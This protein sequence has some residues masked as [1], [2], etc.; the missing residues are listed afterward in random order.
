MSDR[1][2]VGDEYLSEPSSQKVIATSGVR[3]CKHRSFQ[4]NP[5]H[6]EEML[7][8]AALGQFDGEVARSG[9]TREGVRKQRERER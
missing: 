4:H 3:L 6:G 9:H 5:Q 7:R 2:L 8:S 1:F